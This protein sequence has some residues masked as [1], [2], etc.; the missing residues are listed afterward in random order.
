MKPTRSVSVDGYIFDTL[1]RDLVGHNKKASAFITHLFLWS[2][3]WGRNA[4][5][6][7][8]SLQQLAE[9]TGLSKSA[10]Q[11]AIRVLTHREL[12]SVKRH[13]PT[14]IPEYFLHRR[15]AERG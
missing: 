14:A 2:R 6:T 15:W 5:S 13:G 3:T 12:L 7:R 1:M 11:S 10:V 4:A 8:I 9:E